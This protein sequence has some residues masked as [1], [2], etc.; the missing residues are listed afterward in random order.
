MA[1]AVSLK[2]LPAPLSL[3]RQRLPLVGLVCLLLCVVAADIVNVVLSVLCLLFC[4][5]LS[6]FCSGVDVGFATGISIVGC[7][8]SVSVAAVYGGALMMSI[9]RLSCLSGSIW[10][11][12][13]VAL[14]ILP[15]MPMIDSLVIAF[16]PRNLSWCGIM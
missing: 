12:L 8:T 5:S 16:L 1:T 3:V 4:V 11:P 7:S 15:C 13:V 9:N 6:L 10:R 14:I 2:D